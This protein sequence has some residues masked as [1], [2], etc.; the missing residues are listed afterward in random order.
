MYREHH[1]QSLRSLWAAGR[2]HSR[3]QGQEGRG[4]N[5]PF[6]TLLQWH[7]L[8]EDP[9]T[10]A[11]LDMRHLGQK[12]VG[13]LASLCWLPCFAL[14]HSTC[15]GDPL[16]CAQ[17]RMRLWRCHH[18]LDQDLEWLRECGA[19]PP[20]LGPSALPSRGFYQA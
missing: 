8:L 17:L 4:V 7:S 13:Q 2:I 3:R 20:Q 5:V 14:L 11:V 12:Q 19:A 18:Y 16:L 6:V 15:V 10:K 1:E 9:G